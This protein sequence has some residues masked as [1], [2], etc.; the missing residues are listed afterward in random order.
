MSEYATLTVKVLRASG[1]RAADSNGFSD[2]YV[3]L[4]VGDA[5]PWRS[6]LCIG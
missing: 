2:P 6:S 4:R 1:L 3:I 5:T